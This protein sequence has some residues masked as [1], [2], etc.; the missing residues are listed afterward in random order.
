MCCILSTKTLWHWGKLTYDSFFYREALVQKEDAWFVEVYDDL[1]QP[2]MSLKD[3][4]DVRWMTSRRFR[5]LKK[6]TFPTPQDFSS[7]SGLDWAKALIR[8]LEDY[9]VPVLCANGTLLGLIRDGSLIPWDDDLDLIAPRKW[10][11]SPSFESLLLELNFQGY[12]VRTKGFPL[13]PALSIHRDGYKASIAGF[14]RVGRFYL[15][16]SYRL[17]VPLVSEGDFSSPRRVH[18]LG[19]LIAVP[20]RAEDLLDFLYHEWKLPLRDETGGESYL[21]QEAKNPIWFRI[22]LRVGNSIAAVFSGRFYREM[23]SRSLATLQRART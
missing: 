11:L 21:K 13:F 6:R 12:I 18:A 17:P 20:N 14:L 1:S 10:L 16:P 9:D 7:Q 23:F 22:A 2:G 5:Q 4:V 15:R 8:V 19:R 3:L